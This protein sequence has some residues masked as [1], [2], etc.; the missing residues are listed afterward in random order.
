MGN[1]IKHCKVQTHA[2]MKRLFCHK[3]KVLDPSYGFDNH[4]VLTELITKIY[5]YPQ[6][7]AVV[8]L[9][10]PS[11]VTANLSPPVAQR[12]SG[13]ALGCG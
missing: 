7:L 6:E 12:S 5:G 3:V 4:D 10:Q 2:A 1:L 9:N 11:D 8:S 13:R